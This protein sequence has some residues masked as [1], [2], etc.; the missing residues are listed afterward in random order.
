MT[1]TKKAD[2]GKRAPV[3]TER[4]VAETTDPTNSGHRSAEALAS[5]A[6]PKNAPPT[7]AADRALWDQGRFAKLNG[8]GVDDAPHDSKSDD[9]KTWRKGWDSVDG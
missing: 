4:S 1:D 9:F 6:K 8:I 7:D 5:T 3:Q 2:T